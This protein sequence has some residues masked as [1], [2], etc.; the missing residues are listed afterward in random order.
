M[1]AC[2]PYWNI[3]VV[4]NAADVI[5]QCL[6][7]DDWREALRNRTFTGDSA[8][9]AALLDDIGYYRNKFGYEF[10]VPPPVPP[11]EELHATLWRRLE[12]AA[13]AEFDL[14]IREEFSMMRSRI[15]DRITA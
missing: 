14:S 12:Y 5:W 15:R 4:Y 3:Q 11:P 2:R 13:R 6:A 10:V 1:A 7:D 9:P 8:L